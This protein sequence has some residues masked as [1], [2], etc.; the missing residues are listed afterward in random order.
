M[1][2]DSNGIREINSL[3]V[4]HYFPQ[5]LGMTVI[6]YCVCCASMPLDYKP[7][8]KIYDRN[9]GDLMLHIDYRL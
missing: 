8:H 7:L 3:T 2:F 9:V 1:K 5:E 4:Y 6:I